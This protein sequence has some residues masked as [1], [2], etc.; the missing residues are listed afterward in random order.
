[1]NEMKHN[2][3]LLS[4]F[5]LVTQLVTGQ[6]A[7]PLNKRSMRYSLGY[8]HFRIQDIQVSPFVYRSNNMP[9][10]IGYIKETDNSIFSAD[11]GL[12]L[13]SLRNKTFSDRTFL[14]TSTDNEGNNIENEYEMGSF[15]IIQENLNFSYLRKTNLLKNDKYDLYLGASLNQDFLLSFTVV[16]IFVVSS[17]SLNPMAQINCYLD[18]KTLIKS[19]LSFP[20]TGIMSRLPYSN[21]PADGKHSSFISVYTMGTK[22]VHPLNYQKI[23]FSFSLS[24]QINERLQI[25]Y[26][27]TFNWMH[28]QPNRG[29]RAY[30][31]QFNI[32]LTRKF[33]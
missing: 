17:A 11:F 27:Y 16:P 26:I 12:T 19:S 4:L 22:M 13:G 6:D 5:V 30:N 20:L 28:Y 8:S 21:D 24:K 3:L 9:L 23:N 10:G 29:I 18:D 7:S 15:P 14:K 33:K 1:M 25:D 31:N 2:L 32:Q